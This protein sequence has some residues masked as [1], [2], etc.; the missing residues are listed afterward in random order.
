MF[1]IVRYRARSV[2]RMSCCSPAMGQVS[3]FVTI[4]L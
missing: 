3:L 2:V 1:D 4:A